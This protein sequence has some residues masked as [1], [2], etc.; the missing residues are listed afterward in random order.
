MLL[1]NAGFIAIGT[2]KIIHA[3]LL[4]KLYRAFITQVKYLLVDEQS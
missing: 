3:F 1:N 2:L 4:I